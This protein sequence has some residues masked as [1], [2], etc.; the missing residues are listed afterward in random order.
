[1][2][3]N[4]KGI[5]VDIG[6]NTTKFNQALNRLQTPINKTSRELKDISRALKLDPKNTDLLRQKQTVLADALQKTEDKAEA[7]NRTLEKANADGT[8]KSSA[9][10]RQLQREI[11][12]TSQDLQKLAREQAAVN[13]QS[14]RFGRL[15]TT[16]SQVAPKI[17]KVGNGFMKVT[18][19]AA[20]LSTA[21]VGISLTKAFQKLETLEEVRA[22]FKGLGYDAEEVQH[23]MDSTTSS[24]TGTKYA[25]ND[26]AKIAKGAMGAGAEEQYGL[27]KYLTRVADLSAFTGQSVDRFGL[28]MNKALAKGSVDARILNQMLAGG[29]PIYSDLAKSMGV[30]QD[31]LKK[32]VAA[33]KVGFDDLYKA[34][35]KYEGLAQQ[36]GMST[37][38]GAATILGQTWTNV[39]VQF[40]QG[41]YEP[42]KAGLSNMVTWLKSNMD[43]VKRWGANF[44]EALKALI[45]YA[46]YGGNA[47][48]NLSGGAKSIAAVFKPIVGV[49]SGLVKGFAALSPRLKGAAVATALLTGPILKLTAGGMKAYQSIFKLVTAFVKYRAGAAAAATATKT[50]GAMQAGALGLSGATKGVTGL[51]TALGGLS[52]AVPYVAAGVGALTLA[53]AGYKLAVRESQKTTAEAT[54][55]LGK[56][57]ASNKKVSDSF[58]MAEET[59]RSAINEGAGEL[60]Y[61]GQLNQELQGLVDANG[62]VKAGYGDR[63]QYI[64][65]KLNSE[66]DAGITY[67]NGV[68]NYNQ[69]IA[70]SIQKVIDK[71]QAE[72]MMNA[73][74]QEYQEKLKNREKIITDLG[75]ATDKQKEA[76]ERLRN[77]QT[78]PNN[79][80]TRKAIQQTENDIKKYGDQITKA[81]TKLDDLGMA[82]QKLTRLSQAAAKGDVEA[83]KSIVGGVVT[84]TEQISGLNEQSLKEMLKQ[85]QY[86][87]D[88]LKTARA[89]GDKSITDAQIKEAER[90]VGII[91]QQMQ[92][93]QNAINGSKGGFTT[94]ARNAMSGVSGG[95]K[96]NGGN[97]A[98]AALSVIQNARAKMGTVS[99]YNTGKNLTLGLAN[100][101]DNPEAKAKVLAVAKRLIN[102]AIK[103]LNFTGQ[104]RSPSRRTMQTGRFLAEGVAVGMQQETQKVVRAASES[105]NNIIGAMDTSASG[106][107]VGLQG[108]ADS[109]VNG[110]VTAQGMTTETS[111]PINITLYAYPGGA[112][113][114][115]M[116]VDAYDR[117][118]RR[119]G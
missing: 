96:A 116:I 113:M 38:G 66:L 101:M 110:I 93:S 80:A 33:G 94:A 25:L 2:A 119:I 71:K 36:L 54:A 30:T 115:S 42:L 65:D 78:Q 82:E 39:G 10:Y 21:L 60:Q 16:F 102:A 67:A 43:T 48:D 98:T 57:E 20:G 63:A 99:T 13:L 91:K 19:A 52:T 86:Y 51:T 84:S 64:I 4:I 103:T 85:Q 87:L 118:K 6:A 8:D 44:G 56:L 111:Q 97:V 74:E 68:T 1:M 3:Q 75:N 22:T 61:Y 112:V 106:Y 95:I 76:E 105:M 79:M 31:E 62:R 26:M 9:N 32:M 108:M 53:F 45:E 104:I 69:R 23:I 70:D 50:L 47:F 15:N 35:A 100:G 46:R 11:L 92:D 117:G 17:D 40:L 29:L 73:Y 89:N 72:I 83:M 14:T 58:R 55:E 49:I 18:K 114:D 34:T 90:S 5:T 88:G 81:Q 12:K 27:D 41:A 24:V 77:L 107:Q 109:V 28:I 59:R 37:I 7:L